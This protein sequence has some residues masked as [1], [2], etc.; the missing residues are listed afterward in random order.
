MTGR[1]FSSM[2]AFLMACAPDQSEDAIPYVPFAD[3]NIN[4]SLPQ[5]FSL[6]SAGNYL[7]ISEGGVKGLI[8][9]HH[10]NGQFY[11][12]D[13]NC[14]FQ[15]L[16]A[17]STV[18]VDITGL[19]LEDSCCGSVFDFEGNPIDGPARRPLRRYVTHVAGTQLVVTDEIIE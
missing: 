4:L 8:L 11:A 1:I 2:I 12:F 13:R 3:V 19:R 9:F 7:L 14:S 6:Q 15:P 10:S 17:C 18:G 5:Y 16:D